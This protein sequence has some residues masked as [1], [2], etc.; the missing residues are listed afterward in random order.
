[1]GDLG[2][3]SDLVVHVPAL[4][5]WSLYLHAQRKSQAMT[6]SAHARLI[7]AG[8]SFRTNPHR[9]WVIYC[10]PATGKW[11]AADEA[12][13][14][15]EN[16]RRVAL[17]MPLISAD[18]ARNAWPSVELSRLIHLLENHTPPR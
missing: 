11:H 16:C 1:M 4:I 17:P 6:Q 18:A 9:G 2:S 10:D 3:F 12:L 13:R 14:L 8:W 5:P 7:D 15:A